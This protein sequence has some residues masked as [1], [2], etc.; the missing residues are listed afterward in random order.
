MNPELSALKSIWD[1]GDL[2]IIH[3]AGS[4]DESRSHFD[5]Q[6]SMEYA[7]FDKN[8][9]RNGWLSKY[10]EK[11]QS[12]NDSVFRG[13]SLNDAIQKSLK[14][15]IEALTIASLDNFDIT[16]HENLYSD[17]RTTLRNM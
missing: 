3:A 17:T 14:G 8:N 6:D 4:P 1:T 9:V 5:A 10:L 16:T 15:N 7:N 13:V 12:Q 11:T 2:A